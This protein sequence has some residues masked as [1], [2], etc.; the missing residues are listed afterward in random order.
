MLDAKLLA[1]H[2]EI[3]AEVPVFLK[4]PCVYIKSSKYGR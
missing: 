4:A 2:N 3:F 1:L